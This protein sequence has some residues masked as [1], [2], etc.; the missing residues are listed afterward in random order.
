[1]FG[2]LAF[3]VSVTQ[4]K[5]NWR[6]GVQKEE[7]TNLVTRASILLAEILHFWV[8]IYVYRNIVFVL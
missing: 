6:A 3:I 5:E 7:K 2:V 8:L 1:M 4:M